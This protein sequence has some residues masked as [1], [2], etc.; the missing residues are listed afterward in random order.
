MKKN[1]VLWLLVP[2]SSKGLQLRN[3][4]DFSVATKFDS[5]AIFHHE[6][7]QHFECSSNDLTMKII[8]RYNLAIKKWKS[9]SPKKPSS[10]KE[11]LTNSDVWTMEVQSNKRFAKTNW[12]QDSMMK[13][14][15]VTL[16]LLISFLPLLIL[17]F[18]AL[19]TVVSHNCYFMFSNYSLLS[20]F[21]TD[22][23]LVK[24]T[25]VNGMNR[26]NVSVCLI[27]HSS[28]FSSRHD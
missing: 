19:P 18:K 14:R 2:S 11:M 24:T 16:F 9:Y 26:D 17:V 7:V 28:F 20:R 22:I 10:M 5:S 4:M 13:W 6:F 27:L 15:L 3:L 8:E 23:W 1:L 25:E 21:L 12:E